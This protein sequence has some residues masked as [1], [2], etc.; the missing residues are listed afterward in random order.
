MKKLE[1]LFSFL[2]SLQHTWKCGDCDEK[3]IGRD[4]WYSHRQNHINERAAVF[5]ANLKDLEE[6][7]TKNHNE[8]AQLLGRLG[9]L[10]F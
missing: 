7:I 4:T 8:K 3:G 10:K 6:A 2:L 5:R 9:N 1:K